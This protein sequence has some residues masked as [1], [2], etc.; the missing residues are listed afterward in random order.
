MD[1]V[2]KLCDCVDYFAD[3]MKKKLI[4]KAHNGWTGWNSPSREWPAHCQRRLLNHAI[5][6]GDGTGQEIDVANFAMFLWNLSRLSGSKCALCGDTGKVPA[7]VGDN[8][9]C[10]DCGGSGE[11]TSKPHTI[12]VIVDE[13][14]D[15]VKHGEEYIAEVRKL[16]KSRVDDLEKRL[17]ALEKTLDSAGS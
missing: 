14:G 13:D 17:K 5:R 12:T 2:K 10:P 11:A 3:A 7:A 9:V 8:C 16:R 1:D 4:E 6:C 15:L